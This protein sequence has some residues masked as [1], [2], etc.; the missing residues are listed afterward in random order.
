MELTEL[1]GDAATG[2]LPPVVD[3]SAAEAATVAA[4]CA[5]A[6]AREALGGDITLTGPAEPVIGGFGEGAFACRLGGDLPAPWDDVVLVRLATM[7]DIRRERDWHAF[8]RS[9]GHALPEVLGVVAGGSDAA[10]GA[11]VMA[12]GPSLSLMEALG[13]NPA[14]I[15]QLL[16]AMAEVH[17]G[18]HALPLEGAPGSAVAPLDELDRHLDAAGP[19]LGLRAERD[20]LDRHAPEE[21]APVVCH[22]DVQPSSLRL[23]AEDPSSAV[24]VNWSRARVADAEYDIALTLLMFWSAPYLAEGI[25]QRKMLKTVRDMITDGYRAAYEASPG[26]GPLDEGRLRYW[27]AFHALTWSARLSAADA[28]GGPA[29]PWDPVA[30]VQHTASYRKDLARRFAR[31]TRD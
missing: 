28:A 31:L 8:C 12:R 19:A 18:V 20:W 16:R 30:L 13:R 5:Q 23:E 21:T 1:T 24:L 14:A 15:P 3:G 6:C 22:G 7:G 9:R 27:G 2:V 4:E 25:G 11:I 29:S 17:A 26:R 10:P